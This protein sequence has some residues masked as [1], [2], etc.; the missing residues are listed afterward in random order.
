MCTNMYKAF[1]ETYWN[2]NSDQLTITLSINCRE[3]QL[4]A[5]E[6]QCTSRNAPTCPQPIHFLILFLPLKGR[7]SYSDQ[8]TEFKH[9][10][11]VG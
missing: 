9:V 8:V 4:M 5:I 1:T 11:L 10:N 7:V 2:R 3:V 6:I